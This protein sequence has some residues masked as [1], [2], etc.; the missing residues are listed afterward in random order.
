MSKGYANKS[1]SIWVF[2]QMTKIAKLLTAQQTDW[3]VDCAR[4]QWPTPQRRGKQFSP[5]FPS[6]LKK[7]RCPKDGCAFHSWLPFSTLGDKLILARAFP[8]HIVTHPNIE[9]SFSPPLFSFPGTWSF[10]GEQLPSR[11]WYVSHRWRT[12]QSFSPPAVG[13]AAA[14]SE[15]EKQLAGNQW[16]RAIEPAN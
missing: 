13:H 3:M 15:P 5:T 1:S 2:R 6:K 11:T 12:G 10:Q 4:T 8:S 16:I 7:T 9:S 14:S